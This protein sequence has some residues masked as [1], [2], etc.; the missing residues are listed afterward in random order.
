M[1]SALFLGVSMV[2]V[3]FLGGYYGIC[4]VSRELLDC[5]YYF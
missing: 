2:S 1:V 4:I 3:L 5:L